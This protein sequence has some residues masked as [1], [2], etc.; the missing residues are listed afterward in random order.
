VKWE[1]S[2]VVPSWVPCVIKPNN[3]P[4]PFGPG[5]TSTSGTPP[6][7]G[8]VDSVGLAQYRPFSPTILDVVAGSSLDSLGPLLVFF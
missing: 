8:L 6:V 3:F 2:Q 4:D 7:T 5:D 1:K